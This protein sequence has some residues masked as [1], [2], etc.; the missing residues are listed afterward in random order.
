MSLGKELRQCQ[1]GEERPD[2]YI[3]SKENL[4]D[5]RDAPLMKLG[6]AGAGKSTE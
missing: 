5:Q 2:S 1:T 3:V 6:G 4:V